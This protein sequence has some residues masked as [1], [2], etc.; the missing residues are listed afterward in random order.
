MKKEFKMFNTD[1]VAKEHKNPLVIYH[2]NCADGFSAAWCFYNAQDKWETTFDFH[3]GVYGEDIF[4]LVDLEDRNIYLVDF[5]YKREV[6]EKMLADYNCCITL[7]D[8]HKTAIEDLAC[9]YDTNHPAWENRFATR[10]LAYVD[11]ERSGAMLAWDFLHNTTR[12]SIS[13]GNVNTPWGTIDKQDPSYVQPPLLLEHVQDRDLWKFKLDGT[14]PIQAGMFSYE[15]T[16]KNWDTMM[17]PDDKVAQITE[18]MRLWSQGAAIE[19]KHFKDIREL[20]KLCA[21]WMLISNV[22][23]PVASL[24]YTMASD[25]CHIMASEMAHP[26]SIP[27]PENKPEDMAIGVAACY[28]DTA[29]HRV[30]SLR[31]TEA[32]GIDVSEIA[33]NFGGGGHKHAAGFKVKRSHWLAMD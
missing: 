33:K 26:H 24:P 3:P 15:Y 5:S 9:F 27:F 1:F 12:N 8:H 4:N 22:Y 11:L 31:S 6:I 16:F 20:I 2:G 7:I 17:C 19:R 18:K 29:E 21:R 25:A 10:F 32:S 23:M 14:R 28:Y 30:F 13:M